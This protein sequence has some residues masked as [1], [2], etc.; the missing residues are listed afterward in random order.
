MSDLLILAVP[1]DSDLGRLG[2]ALR[3]AV[4]IIEQSV[5]ETVERD[6]YDRT[7]THLVAIEAGAVVGVL[8]MV[9]LPEHVKIGRVA[10]AL[11]ARGKGIAT[12]MM[13]Y[14]MELSRDRGET[15]FYLTSQ[16]DKIGLYERLG[17]VAFGDEF[18]EGGM[19]HKAMKTY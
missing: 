13:Q 14:A 7:A 12:Q 6:H 19:P 9:F 1:V 11:A 18:H 17:F 3:R 16:L 5:P 2:L 10:V 4:F 15:R 8:R